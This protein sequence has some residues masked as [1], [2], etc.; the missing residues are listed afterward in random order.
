MQIIVTDTA[1]IWNHEN[2]GLEQLKDSVLVVCLEGKPVSD[3]Y[4]CFVSPYKQIGMGVDHFGAESQR[5]KALESV[6]DDL[7]RELGYHDKILF[8]TDGNPE[9]LYPFHVIKDRNA[10]NSLH[11]CTIS[12]WRFEGK[13]R[14]KAHRELLS[15]LSRLKSILYIDSNDYLSRISQKDKVY[16][17]DLMQWVSDDY[18]ALLPRVINGIQDMQEQSYFDFTSRSYVPVGEGF[19]CIDLAKAADEIPEIKGPLCRK[20]STLGAVTPQL[21]PAEDDNIK[22]EIER[23]HAR[24]DGKSVCNY[25]RQ[26]RIELARANGIEFFSEECPSVGP[27]AGTCAKCDQEAAYLRDQLANIPES[28][29]IIPAFELIEWEVL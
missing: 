10:F 15:D 5:Y 21:Y 8:L 4:E 2:P 23:V 6:A 26:L 19:D 3:Q 25:L 17:K 13:R 16:M 11:L 14:I 29:R 1:F 18:A 22:E 12:P 7:N 9:S 28:E 20:W 24:I 27:C